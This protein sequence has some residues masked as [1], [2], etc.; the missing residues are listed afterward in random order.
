MEKTT[1]RNQVLLRGT[2]DSPPRFSH[3][4]H[5]RR[6]GIFPLRIQRLSG[7]EDVVNVVADY[8]LLETVDPNGGDSLC[9]SGELRSFNNRSGYGSK[10]VI[11]VYA[12]EL[13]TEDGFDI[14]QVSIIGC[15]CK[16][17]V[18]RTTPLGRDIC[19]LMLAV[20]RRYRRTDYLPVIA[21]GRTARE[22]AELPVGTRLHVLGRIQS[23]KYIKVIE[24]QSVE[25]IA[26]E[27]SA[28]TV[29]VMADDD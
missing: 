22:M 16:P 13:E 25:R 26:Y 27:I 7:N 20:N 28:I 17:P 18:F 2:V 12:E 23:R 1:K 9:V 24:N 4:N 5:D 11:N 6:F 10:L 3:E 14:N 15:I 8:A 21:W 19:D 29:D